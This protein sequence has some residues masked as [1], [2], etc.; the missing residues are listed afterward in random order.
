M[1]EIPNPTFAELDT[2]GEADTELV[3]YALEHAKEL[4]DAR[5][6]LNLAPLTEQ[7]FGAVKDLQASGLGWLDL[8]EW[9]RTH[10]GI[11]HPEAVKV[12]DLRWQANWLAE[13]LAGIA[14]AEASLSH[15]RSSLEHAANPTELDKLGTYIQFSEL[16]GGDVWKI[17]YIRNTRYALCFAELKYRH[18]RAS[19]QSR[20]QQLTM[21]QKR[22]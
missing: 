15:A 18:E 20:L 21:K 6:V 4:A 16:A 19:Y 1:I 5:N 9:L 17:E 14:R 11:T 13:Q 3:A 2:L 22:I 7:T 8:L 10:A 12:F